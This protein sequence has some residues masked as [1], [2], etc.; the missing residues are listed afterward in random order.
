M[1][2]PWGDVSAVKVL[3]YPKIEDLHRAQRQLIANNFD[4]WNLVTGRVGKGKSK[5]ARKNARK[6]D[7][8]FGLDRIHF[9]EGSFWDQYVT[10]QPGDAIILDEFRGHRRASMHGDRIEMLE[11]I[12]RVRSR[13]LHVFV[14][15]DRVSTLDR[16]LLTDRNA[17]WHHLEHK[18]NAMVRQPDTKLRFKLDSTPI[19]PTTYPLVGDYDFTPWEPPG[20]EE[21][22][23]RKKHGAQDLLGTKPEPRNLADELP[24]P[25][26]TY[27]R[28]D[29][30]LA[31]IAQR[32]LS[33]PGP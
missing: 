21:A 33:R 7:R 5:W 15:Y 9:D 8:G 20:F 14:V 12:K 2:D 24:P 27:G 4:D 25:P 1:P 18:G 32:E 30:I 29:M 31:D 22:Y 6:L 3:K 28:I 10:L 23:E 17:Y 16:D 26:K 19:E 13:F 11:R